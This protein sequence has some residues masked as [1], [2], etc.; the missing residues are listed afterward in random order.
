MKKRRKIIRIKIRRRLNRY[1]VYVAFMMLLEGI[2]LINTVH[3]DK[4]YD[5]AFKYV[6]FFF[7]FNF[8]MGMDR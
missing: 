4:Q 3:S 6:R 2:Q 7:S 1:N 8:K 5:W